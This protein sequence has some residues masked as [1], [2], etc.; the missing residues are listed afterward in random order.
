MGD[1]AGLDVM[2]TD[3]VSMAEQP[4]D[5]IFSVTLTDPV[6]GVVHVTLM[7]FVF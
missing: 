1:V 6:P 3:F 7:A 5:V 4:E 2:V